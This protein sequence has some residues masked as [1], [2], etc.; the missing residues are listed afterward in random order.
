M[1]SVR[2]AMSSQLENIEVSY[3]V[4]GF[5]YDHV[6][7][8]G[9]RA[10]LSFHQE[11]KQDQIHSRNFSIH[12]TDRGGLITLHNIGQLVI[13]PILPLKTLG[14]GVRDYLRILCSA[15]ENFLKQS[16]QISCTWDMDHPDGIFVKNQKVAFIGIRVIQGV[17]KHGIALNLWNNVS[18]FNLFTPCGQKALEIVN[19]Q[20]I[21]KEINKPIST[22]DMPF[23]FDE[24]CAHLA[25]A[26][27]RKTF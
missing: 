26:L 5:E 10:Q 25:R 17:T 27:N 3:Q 19:L 2:A 1:E 8:L 22:S 15:T 21:C 20:S 13:Y 23:I 18:E 24:W 11:S 4:L 16:Y 14:F 12:S 6:L 9:K 7:T